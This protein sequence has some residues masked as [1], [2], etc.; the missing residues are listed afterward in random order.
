MLELAQGCAGCRGLPVACFGL[1]GP[2][3]SGD[4]GSGLQANVASSVFPQTHIYTHTHVLVPQVPQGRCPRSSLRAHGLG[5][6]ERLDPGMV[7]VPRT[8]TASVPHLGA[9]PIPPNEPLV[10]PQQEAA[11]LPSPLPVALPAAVSVSVSLCLSPSIPLGSP[12]PRSPLFPPQLPRELG[13]LGNRAAHTS[14]S[15]CS[16]ICFCLH[17]VGR[18]Q[19]RSKRLMRHCAVGLPRRRAAGGRASRG[20]REL[21]RS[22]LTG[23]KSEIS[24]SP[25]VNN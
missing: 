12:L 15:H 21:I 6:H 3:L 2:A 25:T 14:R 20:D 13:G 22:S 18:R 17:L 8:L 5:C 4:W 24:S 9:L 7:N 23:G 19:E 1:S 10:S 16:T 11:P